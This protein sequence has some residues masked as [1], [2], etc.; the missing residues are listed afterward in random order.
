MRRRQEEAV[1]ESMNLGGND[2]EKMIRGV[3]VDAANNFNTDV[4]NMRRI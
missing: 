3:G 4:H 2:D 1:T